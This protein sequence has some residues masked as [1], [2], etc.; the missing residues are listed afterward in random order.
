MRVLETVGANARWIMAGGCVAALFLP[1]LSA[2]LRPA[3]PFLVSVVLA[4]AMTRIDLGEIARGA[5]R[6]ARLGSWLAA[7][8][9]MMPVAAMLMWLLGQAA[10]PEDR[11]L[12]ILYALAPPIASSAGISFLMRYDAQRAVEVTVAATLLTP[13]IGPALL[14]VMLPELPGLDPVPLALRLGAMVAGGVAMAL[15]AKA[16]IGRD[17]IA[18]SGRKFDGIAACIMVLFVIP[19][20][21]GV[22]ATILADPATALRVLVLSVALNLGINIAVIL[23][24]ERSLGRPRAGAYGV[25]SG[26]RTVALYLA[27]LPYDPHFALFVALYQFP[28]YLTPLALGAL[29]LDHRVQEDAA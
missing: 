11:P 26:N 8:A 19:L 13:L 2:L 6:P 24:G 28:M 7:I 25:M 5:I 4:T 1:S 9:L 12:L 21:D 20:F 16:L 15:V 3:L 23:I 10:L 29:G 18:R 17:R 22:G 27:A 14:A